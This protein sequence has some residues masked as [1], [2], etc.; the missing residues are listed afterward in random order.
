MAARFIDAHVE[1]R[2]GGDPSRPLEF[3]WQDRRYAI[4]EI[5]HQ[6][7]DWGFAPGAPR[8]N[9]RSRRHRNY[10]RVRTERDGGVFGIY[11][12]RGTKPGREAWILFQQLDTPDDAAEEE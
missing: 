11:L 2:T 7:T 3:Q 9:W 10:Y 4:I 5:L 8:R 12:D 1:V 6:W